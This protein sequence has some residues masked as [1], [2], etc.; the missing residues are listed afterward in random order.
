MEN[1][2]I[3]NSLKKEMDEIKQKPFSREEVV[4]LSRNEKIAIDNKILWLQEENSTLHGEN[5]KL[6]EQLFQVKLALKN[7]INGV[8][9]TNEVKELVNR[10]DWLENER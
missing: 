9:F 2:E 3:M 10:E 8:P 6:K 4:I 7:T 1:K 5:K